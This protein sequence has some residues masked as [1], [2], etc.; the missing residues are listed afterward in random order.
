M[1]EM[2]AHERWSELLPAY[3]R[4]ELSDEEAARVTE[5]LQ[6]CP[7]CAAEQRGL[8]ALAAPEPEP[9]TEME[10]ARMRRAVLEEAV[11]APDAAPAAE[12]APAPSDRRARLFP[13]LGA[14]AVALAIAVFAYGGGGGLGGGDAGSTSDAPEGAEAEGGEEA[15]DAGA[16]QDQVTMEDAAGGSAAR[17]AP[18]DPTFKASI[19]D[20][21]ATR[22]NRLGRRGLSLVVFSRALTAADVPRLRDD[23]IDRL[24][25]RAPA[26]RGRQI[27]ECAADITSTFPNSL[28]AYGAV[29]NFTDGPQREVLILAFAWTNE[30]QGPLD[31]SMVWAWPLGTCDSVAHYSKNVIEPRT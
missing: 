17:A 5:H 9:L 18:P 21:D 8:I 10:R 7:A 31:Q 14:A 25:R 4:G 6:E 19:G 13:L 2:N 27:R 16:S 28:P 12:T 22:L 20:V 29:G 30:D 11:P 24:A 3:V 15:L 23:F 1:D 26:A